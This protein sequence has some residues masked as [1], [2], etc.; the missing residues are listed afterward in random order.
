MAGA[1]A[2]GSGR[3]AMAGLLLALNACSAGNSVGNLL[4]GSGAP[5]GSEVIPGFIGAVVADEPN[6]ALAGRE[7]LA[8]GGNA[9]DAATALAFALTATYPSRAGLGGG[10]ACMVYKPGNNGTQIPDAL[11]FPPPAPQGPLQGDRPAAVPLMARGLFALQARYGTLPIEQLV[12]PGE[13]FARVGVSVSRAFASDL[14]AVGPA[15]LGDP[16]ARAVFGQPNGQVLADGMLMV[17]PDLGA[18]LAQIRVSGIGDLYQGAMAQRLVQGSAQA[19]GPFTLDDLRRTV[20]R[21]MNPI[22]VQAGRDQLALPPPPAD[23]GLATAV[24][25]EMLA[26]NPGNVQG[27][28][29]ASVAAVAQL[30]TQGGNYQTLL[31]N[32]PSGGAALPALG[33]STGF[34]VLDRN[35]MAVSCALT[36]NNLFG[37]GRIAAGTGIL[38]AASPAATPP[39]LLAPGIVFNR[40]LAA[41]RAEAASS[42]QA[43]AGLAEAVALANTLRSP[44]PM[45]APVPDP[46]R[47]NV[48]SCSRYLPSAA[49][50]CGWAVDP[51]VPGLAVGQ[52]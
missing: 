2:V 29:N 20:P 23:G 1:V 13:R 11:V 33:A 39:P 46:G 28:L 50:S 43:G 48:I 3:A 37:T 32:P 17:Q 44:V 12:A 47:S 16:T 41:F 24:A 21:L 51:R 15:L 7:V 25:F 6:A 30:R 52:E 38:L 8:H 22:L 27:A 10:G 42:G 45:P 18:T 26:R 34:V 36:M 9:A 5:T 4:F 35:G 40:N 14:A 49:G 19:G 31:T